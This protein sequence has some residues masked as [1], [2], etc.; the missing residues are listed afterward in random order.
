ML[1][2]HEEQERVFR[3]QQSTENVQ[4]IA[5]RVEFGQPALQ[6]GPAQIAVDMAGNSKQTCV[7][8]ACDGI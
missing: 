1:R 3:E 7:D 5:K 8:L 2:L 4:C 6:D